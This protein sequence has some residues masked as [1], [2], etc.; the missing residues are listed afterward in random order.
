MC[1]EVIIISLWTCWTILYDKII[2]SGVE[3][4]QLSLHKD[5]L[6]FSV[7]I[8]GRLS[9]QYS[10]D[11]PNSGEWRPSITGHG[12]PWNKILS[13]LYVTDIPADGLPGTTNILKFVASGRKV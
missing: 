13:E 10:N 2:W 1:A 12:A 4:T 11:Y 9:V 3:W 6:K 5:H 7:L 8:S